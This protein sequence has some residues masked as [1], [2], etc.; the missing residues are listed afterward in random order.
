M[1]LC[2]ISSAVAGYID[3]IS[4]KLISGSSSDSSFAY[5]VLIE[6]SAL[7]SSNNSSHNGVRTRLFASTAVAK[8]RGSFKMGIA[9]IL[10]SFRFV[11]D[12]FILSNSRIFCNPFNSVRFLISS[13]G[14]LSKN[15]L[16][17]NACIISSLDLK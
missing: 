11:S 7:P 15:I 10:K 1:N 17:P 6:P 3:G 16:S 14:L 9:A 4:Q 13:K 8:I 12:W 5:S 2:W